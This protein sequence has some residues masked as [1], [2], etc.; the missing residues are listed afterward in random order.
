[1]KKPL[2]AFGAVAA[3]ALAWGSDPSAE[4]L[5]PVRIEAAGQPIDTPTI[6][7]AAP[8]VGDFSVQMPEAYTPQQARRFYRQLCSAP[9]PVG[10]ALVALRDVATLSTTFWELTPI[11]PQQVAVTTI[12]GLDD[13]AEIWDIDDPISNQRRWLTATRFHAP[14]PSQA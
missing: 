11:F 14:N 4:L 7:H 12:E 5:P 9:H 1:M 6:G 10:E 3:A 2:I 13:V 8:F